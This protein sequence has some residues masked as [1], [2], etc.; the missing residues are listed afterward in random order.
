VSARRCFERPDS[1][2]ATS[3]ASS[4]VDR[5]CS[6]MSRRIWR[7]VGSAT[8]RSALTS[9]TGGG[10]VWAFHFQHP[11]V[12]RIDAA[13]GAKRIFSVPGALGTGIAY[14]AGAVWLLTQSPSALIELDPSTGDVRARIAI[15][16]A[17]PPKH[18]IADTWWVAAGGGSLWLTNPN[19]D[20]VTRVD[21]AAAKVR[22][23]IPVPVA[24]PFGIVFYRGAAWVVGS[25]KVV[26]IDPADDRP[27]AALGLAKGADALFTQLAAG[28]SGLWATDYDRGMLYRLRVS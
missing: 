7:R 25:G 27:G 13:T 6:P 1:L 20:R 2:S 4:S 21:I 26:R 19:Y 12:T 15:A 18:A 5:G 11:S 22:A 23:T 9:A 14:A 8:A 10:F 3:G 24:A 16:S 17:G 28:P